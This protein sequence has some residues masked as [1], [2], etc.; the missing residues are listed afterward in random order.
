[1]LTQINT[2]EEDDVL[3]SNNSKSNFITDDEITTDSLQRQIQFLVESLTRIGGEVCKLRVEV[4]GL[5]ELNS[6]VVQHCI[7]LEAV[8]REKEILDLDDFQLAC[9]VFEDISS[10]SKENS[11]SRREYN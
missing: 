10:P 9:E 5:L 3:C 7:K 1:M 11:S 4:D 2:C 6:R 8:I